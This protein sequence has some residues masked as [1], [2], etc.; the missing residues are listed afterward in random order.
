MT[1]YLFKQRI[2]TNAADKCKVHDTTVEK[3]RQRGKRAVAATN[4]LKAHKT[5][6]HHHPAIGM[7]IFLHDQD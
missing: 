7:S 5:N 1:L 3:V 2:K 4:T 6:Y